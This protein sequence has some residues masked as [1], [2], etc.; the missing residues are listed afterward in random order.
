MD[1]IERDLPV[2]IMDVTTTAGIPATVLLA[3]EGVVVAPD[4]PGLARH[5]RDLH[6]RRQVY[7]IGVATMHRASD[8]TDS[9]EAAAGR[10][11]AELDELHQDVPMLGTAATAGKRGDTHEADSSGRRQHRPGTPRRA[12][13]WQ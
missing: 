7:L 12:G 1:L 9:V 5:L 8:L 6:R 2:T 3:E 11:R 13:G 10:L 4:V